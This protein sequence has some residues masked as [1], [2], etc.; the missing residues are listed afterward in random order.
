M[1]PLDT[2][3]ILVNGHRIPVGGV[4]PTPIH[5]LSVTTMG[6]PIGIHPEQSAQLKAWL[7]S[8]IEALDC[9][10]VE[11]QNTLIPSS[12]VRRF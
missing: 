1:N 10:Y 11:Y 4:F 7:N 3:T 9:D 5:T 6:L 12:E 2:I 8:I